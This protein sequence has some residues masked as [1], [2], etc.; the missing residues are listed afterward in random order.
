MPNAKSN[1]VAS[2]L[3]WTAII[4]LAMLL[5][6]LPFLVAAY[7][8]HSRFVLAWLLACLAGHALWSIHLHSLCKTGLVW[9][10]AFSMS[11]L[12]ASLLFPNGAVTWFEPYQ[13]SAFIISAIC[14]GIW[15]TSTQRLHS[16]LKQFVVLLHITAFI[17]AVISVYIYIFAMLDKVTRLGNPPKK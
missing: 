1:Q 14:L 3:L 8:N 13:F 16:A 12:P 11:L 6:I 17:Y 9:A 15:L 10:I 4:S 5:S 7:Y 2:A